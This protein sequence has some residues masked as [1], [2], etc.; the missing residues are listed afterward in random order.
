MATRTKPSHP[1]TPMS[2]IDEVMDVLARGE[3]GLF[4]DLAEAA[5]HPQA[6][7]AALTNSMPRPDTAS[8]RDAV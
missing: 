8:Q 2:L 1:V 4:A 3:R 7:L 6:T 5:W